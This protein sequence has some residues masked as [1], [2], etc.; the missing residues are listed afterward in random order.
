MHLI[1]RPDLADDPALARNDGR[2]LQRARLD[3]AIGA[4]TA[5]P[6]VEDVLAALERA[7]VPAGHIYTVAD[8]AADPHYRAR[9]MILDAH[10]PTA[11]GSN[12]RHRAQAERDAGRSRTAAPGLGEHTDQVLASL[13][14]DIERAAH[15]VRAASSEMSAT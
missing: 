8:I 15:G 12:A 11:L 6:Y 3:A 7:R 4:W 2:V 14:I 10:C 9:E 1:G 5:P 13:G